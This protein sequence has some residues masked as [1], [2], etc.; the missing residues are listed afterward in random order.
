MSKD[1]HPK[2]I[3]LVR[4]ILAMKIQHTTG[5]A[6]A[7]HLKERYN[8]SHMHGRVGDTKTVERWE[9]GVKNGNK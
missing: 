9:G 4:L 1:C 3:N 7:I 2:T 6:N 8:I 5:V